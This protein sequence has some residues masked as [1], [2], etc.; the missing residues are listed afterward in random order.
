MNTPNLTIVPNPTT[1]SMQLLGEMTIT[2]AIGTYA[3][4]ERECARVFHELVVEERKGAE[5][6]E[7]HYRELFKRWRR[8]ELHLSIYRVLMNELDRHL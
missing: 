3:D 1:E 6:D 7:A 2:S 4:N 8:H 5:R